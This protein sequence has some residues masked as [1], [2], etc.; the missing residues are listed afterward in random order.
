ME[1]WVEK[2]TEKKE[3]QKEDSQNKLLTKKQKKNHAEKII[4]R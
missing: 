4:N 2:C 3:S 1:S